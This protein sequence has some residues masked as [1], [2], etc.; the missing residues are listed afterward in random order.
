MV[1]LLNERGIIAK[2]ADGSADSVIL[3]EDG[4][5]VTSSLMAEYEI[6]GFDVIEPGDPAKVAL[7][8]D[9]HDHHRGDYCL[10]FDGS[11]WRS[12]FWS[13]STGYEGL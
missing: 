2:A 8:E 1:E 10:V 5:D 7:F 3:I 9:D 6:D 12:V 11:T 13:Q 4:R